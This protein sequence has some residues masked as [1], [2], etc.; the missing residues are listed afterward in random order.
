MGDA[1][2]AEEMN[3]VCH[4]DANWRGVCDKEIKVT[5]AFEAN[6]GFLVDKQGAAEKL[7]KMVRCL[8]PVCRV[9]DHMQTL[10]H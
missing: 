8:A 9:S 2:L 1:A 3:N 6:W 10:A 4:K 7:E 5:R